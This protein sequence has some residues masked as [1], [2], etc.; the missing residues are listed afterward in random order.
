MMRF[1]L[2]VALLG[3]SVATELTK[4]TWDDAVAGKTVFLKFFAPWCGHCKSMKPDWDKLMAEFEGHATTLVADVD[5][6]AGGKA[7]CDEAGVRGYPTIKHGDPSDLQDYKGGRDLAAL[8]AFAAGL[9]PQCSPSNIDL[10]DDAKKAQ[11]KEFMALGA[12][13]REAQIKVKEAE[14]E[15][16]ESDF[17]SFVE[18]LQ[19]LYSDANEKKDKDIEAMKSSGL[20]LLKSVHAHTKKMGNA[21]L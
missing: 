15:K 7:L 6:T 11:I 20:G 1:V 4:E 5:C 12:A 13:E 21:E 16:L 10:C 9:G 2:L 19:K 17:K 18:G 14:L 3:T 8:K